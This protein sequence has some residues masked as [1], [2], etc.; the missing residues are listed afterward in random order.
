MTDDLSMSISV[1]M[2]LLDASGTRV[3]CFVN[4]VRESDG[5]TVI[6]IESERIGRYRFEDAGWWQ[7]FTTMRRAFE[8]NGWRVL[9]NAARHDLLLLPE[10]PFDYRPPSR[11]EV[12]VQTDDS[13][14]TVERFLPVDPFGPARPD[15]IGTLVDLEAKRAAWQVEADRRR[16]ELEQKRR[17]DAARRATAQAT[18]TVPRYFGF[19]LEDGSSP[20][21]PLI[22]GPV[23]PSL[24]ALLPASAYFRGD[25]LTEL[26]SG[27]ALQWV[28]GSASCGARQE[29]FFEMFEGGPGDAPVRA[30]VVNGISHP[31]VGRR[32][33]LQYLT[34]RFGVDAELGGNSE[35]WRE[36]RRTSEVSTDG[37]RHYDV[38]T[39]RFAD[40][41]ERTIYFDATWWSDSRP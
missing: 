21:V 39:L 6:E 4:M 14:L 23:S 12:V 24:A 3:P 28:C 7:C 33:E 29:R 1:G 35:G 30:V 16:R 8:R 10:P 27:T 36:V 19:C 11:F 40:S 41:T 5:R 38:V 20:L 32:A 22:Y 18:T 37:S 34:E 13:D 31:E 26:L 17:G 15:Q 2:D 9:C 25:P